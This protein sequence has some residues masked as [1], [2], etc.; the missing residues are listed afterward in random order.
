MLS[1]V[2]III[3]DPQ[4]HGIVESHVSVSDDLY[5]DL[6]KSEDPTL[7]GREKIDS[8]AVKYSHAYQIIE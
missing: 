3:Q 4:G 1:F 7:C 5:E 6:E 8:K 2:S